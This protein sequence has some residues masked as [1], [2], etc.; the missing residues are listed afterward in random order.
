MKKVLNHSLTIILIF[1]LLIL[2][3]DI[4]VSSFVLLCLYFNRFEIRVL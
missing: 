4:F 1:S 3:T 2:M